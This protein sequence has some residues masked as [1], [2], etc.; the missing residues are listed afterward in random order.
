MDAHGDAVLRTVYLIVRDM[1]ISE[2]IA[3]EVFVRAYR[4]LHLFKRRSAPSTWLH[5]IAVNLA[6]NHLRSR[7]EIPTDTELFSYRADDRTPPPETVAIDRSVRDTVRACIEG[8]PGRLRTIVVLYYLEERS[9]EDVARIAAIPAGT[10]K[11]RLSKARALLRESLEQE[12]IDG[13]T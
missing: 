12:E 13:T 1:T 9:V 3:Q 10:V 4:K 6:K 5:R 2:E 8:L 11:S 7:R